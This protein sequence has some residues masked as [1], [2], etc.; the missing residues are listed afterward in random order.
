MY[1]A[2]FP[3]HASGGAS[4]KEFVCQWRRHKRQGFDLW[5][6]KIPWRRKWQPAPIFLLGK[7]HGQRS[8]GWLQSTGLQSWTRL[9]AY[10]HTHTNTDAYEGVLVLHVV[11]D[12]GSLPGE[13]AFEISGPFWQ[14][15][16]NH[17]E[18]QFCRSVVWPVLA[19]PLTSAWSQI[20]YFT[21]LDYCFLCKIDMIM[22]P[23]ESFEDWMK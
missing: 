12:E 9:S 7:S 23:L 1:M 5:V 18:L 3:G 13:V 4:G 16:Y 19:L 11:W 10:A 20:S 2:G 15:I 21:P 6:G 22:F 14:M 17:K 8:L